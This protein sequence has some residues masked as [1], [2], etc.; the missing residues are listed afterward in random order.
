MNQQLAIIDEQLGVEAPE[1]GR[2]APFNRNVYESKKQIIEQKII[3]LRSLSVIA[4]D[5][6]KISKSNKDG[7]ITNI[8]DLFQ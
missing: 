8:T 2:V 3:A 6:V 4:S 1:E 7:E 5:Q